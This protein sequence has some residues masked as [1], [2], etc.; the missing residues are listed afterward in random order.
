MPL[1][2]FTHSLL[3]S[4]PL[5]YYYITHKG[6][7]RRRRPRSERTRPTTA[8]LMFLC[9]HRFASSTTAE[10]RG[11]PAPSYQQRLVSSPCS[12]P[13]LSPS[14][15]SASSRG[16]G[17]GLALVEGKRLDVA[18]GLLCWIIFVGCPLS[19]RS[20]ASSLLSCS[21]AARQALGVGGGW[22]VALCPP[23]KIKT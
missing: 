7:R 22:G 11:P 15:R 19:S 21:R 13:R 12:G 17:S 3:I 23:H 9:V 10:F 14:C 20:Q 1:V 6:A 16:C 2:L 5:Q 4:T 8:L 18:G